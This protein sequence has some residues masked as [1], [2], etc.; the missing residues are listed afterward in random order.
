MDKSSLN[1]TTTQH[2]THTVTWTQGAGSTVHTARA[3]QRHRPVSKTAWWVCTGRSSCLLSSSLVYCSL[4]LLASSSECRDPR[5]WVD[6]HTPA[7]MM[8]SPLPPSLL[9][10]AHTHAG[11]RSPGKCSGQYFLKCPTRMFYPRQDD[12]MHMRQRGRENYIMKERKEHSA[13]PERPGNTREKETEEE[14]KKE[15]EGEL[16]R[17]RGSRG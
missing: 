4:F 15:I 10:N 12:I 9:P 11:T 14:K 17:G 2:V 6:Q 7:A 8:N 13:R 3:Q 5:T 16:E 1:L